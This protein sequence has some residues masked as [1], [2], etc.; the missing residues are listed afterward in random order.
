MDYFYTVI[1]RVL[2]TEGNFHAVRIIT[3][4]AADSTIA[5]KISSRS[6]EGTVLN[7]PSI[8]IL[9]IMVLAHLLLLLFNI[10]ERSTIKMGIMDSRNFSESLYHYVTHHADDS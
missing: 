3:I 9:A 1:L 10:L 7:I 6:P 4:S 8:E 5:K 2:S